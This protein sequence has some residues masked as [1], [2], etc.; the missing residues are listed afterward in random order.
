MQIVNMLDRGPVDYMSIDRLQRYVHDEVAALR[1]PD[2][3][4]VWEAQ[5]TYTAGRRTEDKDIPDTSVP[6]IRMDRGGSVTY[7][8]PGQLVVYP[9]VKVRPPRDVVAFVRNTESAI[10]AAL[11]ERGIDSVQVEGRSGVWICEPGTIDRKVCAIGIKFADDATM[12]GLAL[13]VT[14]NLEDFM[15]VIPCGLADAGVTSLAQLGHATTLDD[16]AATLLPHLAR[17]Y[18]QFAL[19][20][21]EG[22]IEA[23]VSAIIAQMGDFHPT[24]HAET[25]SRWQP[26]HS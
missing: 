7:H 14:T 13:N 2:T 24:P 8:G 12:H 6:V 25:G 15:R 17:A 3:F 11:A 10:I 20:P 16:A 18:Q 26:R 19:R 9:I 1:M 23:D 4:I 5:P 22:L 21:S